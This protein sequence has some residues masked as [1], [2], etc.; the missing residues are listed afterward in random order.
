MFQLT[1]RCSELKSQEQ[2]KIL[3][4]HFTHYLFQTRFVHI[5]LKQ[6]F[7]TPSVRDV[8]LAVRSVRLATDGGTQMYC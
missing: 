4:V 3:G 7:R 6:V 1:Q 2:K 8:H 5:S